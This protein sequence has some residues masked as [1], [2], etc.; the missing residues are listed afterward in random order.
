M[1]VYSSC[2]KDRQHS[3]AE[4]GLKS[5]ISAYAMKHILRVTDGVRL[6]LSNAEQG[7]KLLG[8]LLT[9]SVG[10]LMAIQNGLA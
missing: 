7:V 4:R 1:L 5:Y 2:R 8:L 9:G 3:Q 10:Q 6:A